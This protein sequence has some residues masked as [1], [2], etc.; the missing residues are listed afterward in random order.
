MMSAS[1]AAI[2]QRGGT[3]MPPV[4]S[5]PGCHAQTGLGVL[6]R[7]Q[8]PPHSP[9]VGPLPLFRPIRGL[10]RGGARRSRRLMPP[11]NLFRR[12]AALRRPLREGPRPR[13]QEEGAAP[14]PGG[15]RRFAALRRALREGPRPRGQEEGAATGPGGSRRRLPTYAALRFPIGPCV[16]VPGDE[17]KRR[18]AAGGPGG[19]RRRLPSFAASRLPI[20]PCEKVPGHQTR[21]H[22]RRPA[23][24]LLRSR[25]TRH[26]SRSTRHAFPIPFSPPILFPPLALT[27]Q[28]SRPVH[29]GRFAGLDSASAA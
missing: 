13:G 6:S 18:G 12:F 8:A 11:A 29:P 17:A 21:R 26:A 3:G 7:S 5:S 10:A 19:L 2:A 4:L 20:N 1:P 15:L 24:A 27:S 14:G 28:A 16:K 9:L 23:P 22:A 25:V